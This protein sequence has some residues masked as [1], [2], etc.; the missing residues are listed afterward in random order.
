M[1]NVRDPR[2]KA[3]NQKAAIRDL[4]GQLAWARKRI[5]ELGDAPSVNHWRR[6]AQ[7]LEWA[8]QVCRLYSEGGGS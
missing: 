6:R 8:I 5:S 1:T 2:T 4:E 3:V 7:S